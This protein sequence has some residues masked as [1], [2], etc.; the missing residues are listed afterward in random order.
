MG[1]PFS[2]VTDIVI[3]FEPYERNFFLYEENI[4]RNKAYNTLVIYTAVGHDNIVNV[5]LS[6][7]I[8]QHINDVDIKLES[9]EPVNYGAIRLGVGGSPT[10]LIT[11]DS[12]TS[13]LAPTDYVS[14]IKIDIEGA[15]ILAFNGALKTIK[16]NMPCIIYEKNHSILDNEMKTA[17]VLDSKYQLKSPIEIAKEMSYHR[18]NELRFEDIC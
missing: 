16:D 2:V 11:L 3:A 5:S 17:I 4:R 7:R 9:G 12:V 10:Q 8:G 13:K 18:L 14:L 6:D 1:I 15:E